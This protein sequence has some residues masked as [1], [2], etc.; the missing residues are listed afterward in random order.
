MNYKMIRYIL[1]WL[2]R[3]EGLLLMLP[4]IISVVFQEKQG[5][6]Y[7]IFAL[8]AMGAGTLISRRRPHNSEIYQRDGL[9]TVGLAWI[10]MSLYG[11]LPFVVTGEIPFYVDAV[12]E[13]ISGFTTTGS[14]I[15][16]DVE[17]LSHTSLIWRSFSHWTGGMGVLV[18]ILMLIPVRQGAG[19]HMNLMRAESP[20]PEVS[21]FVPRVRNTAILLYKIY[22]VLTLIEIALLLVTGMPW[23]DTLCLSFGTAGTGGFAVLNTSVGSYTAVHQWIITVFMAMFGIN[24]T[25]YYLILC[26]KGREAIRMQEVIAYFVI[27]LIAAVTITINISSMYPTFGESVRH[28]FFQVSSIM[29]T[30]GFGTTDTNVWPALSKFILGSLMIIGAC[31][32]STG[33]GMKVSRVLIIFKA[34]KEELHRLVHPR[35]VR[36]VR[37][38]GRVLSSNTLRAVYIFVIAYF[39]LFLVSTLLISIDNFTFETNFSA[40]AATLNNIG[41]GFG[42]VGA[43]ANFSLFSPFSKIILCIDMLAGRLELFPILILFFPGTWKKN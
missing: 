36:K 11:A 17:A 25:F 28:A 22:I 1:G 37:M 33:G 34:F 32:G 38:D 43:T 18:F 13:I 12:F 41:P 5:I 14:S 4:C 40:V 7:L 24:F 6:T 35:S 42:M 30:T 39:L 2:L 15:L 23:F 27:M 20:G 21:K 16:N 29:T 9:V 31:A 8:I 10:I 26:R 19:T 3:I